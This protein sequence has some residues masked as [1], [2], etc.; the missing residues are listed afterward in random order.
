MTEKVRAA[1]FCQLAISSTSSTN[2]LTNRSTNLQGGNAEGKYGVS[3]VLLL[4]VTMLV[5]Y[6]NEESRHV[7]SA[8]FRGVQLSVCVASAVISTTNMC[9][10]CV[11]CIHRLP[12]LVVIG[13]YLAEEVQN[14]TT[15]RTVL[16]KISTTI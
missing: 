16:Q 2:T 5:Y 9:V 6:I 4:V 8:L 7:A 15:A 1:T 14:V 13:L 12:G 10:D 11:V 3:A